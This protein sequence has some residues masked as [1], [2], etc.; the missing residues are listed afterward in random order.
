MTG[1]RGRRGRGAGN[2][3]GN[4]GVTGWRGRRGRGAGNGRGGR[5]VTG[6]RDRVWRGAYAFA[7]RETWRRRGD[8]RC[9]PFPAHSSSSFGEAVMGDGRVSAKA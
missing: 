7:G 8:D 1:W 2:G 3:R 5:G 9:F 6:W 4:G